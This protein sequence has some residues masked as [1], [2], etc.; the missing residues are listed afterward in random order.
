MRDSPQ[1]ARR[2]GGTSRRGK[3]HPY[4][5]DGAAREETTVSAGVQFTISTRSAGVAPQGRKTHVFLS[6]FPSPRR[7]LPPVPR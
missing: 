4:P 3:A 1:D 6:P 5:A 2:A 7:L